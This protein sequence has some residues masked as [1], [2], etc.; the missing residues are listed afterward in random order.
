[1]SETAQSCG[2]R[3]D[4]ERSQH[5]ARLRC[6]RW[7][8]FL[9][10]AH[11]RRSA[12]AVYQIADAVHAAHAVSSF[13]RRRRWRHR[14]RG[15][16][17]EET[18]G[19]PRRPPRSAGRSRASPR[20]RAPRWARKGRK[21]RVGSAA[22]ASCRRTYGQQ[23]GGART[24]RLALLK[25]GLIGSFEP[26]LTPRDKDLEPGIWTRRVTAHC[27]DVRSGAGRQGG[28]RGRAGRS[29]L[30]GRAPATARPMVRLFSRLA[31]PLFLA[32]RPVFYL[33][34]VK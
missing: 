32:S 26:V 8:C 22:E 10:R 13:L 31:P 18:S 24:L 4:C 5:N 6:I 14:S 27:K 19:R 3:L 11:D 33:S 34:R 28:Y 29:S 16:R 9:R 7:L 12:N 25:P 17:L 1:M 20:R 23:K 30:L 21:R 15:P 2:G